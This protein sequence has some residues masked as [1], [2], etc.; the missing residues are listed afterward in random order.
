MN[1][2]IIIV[3]D[4]YDIPHQYHKSFDDEKV[5]ITEETTGK[6]SQVLGKKVNSF[7]GFNAKEKNTS[8]VSHLES[9]WT[10]IIYLELPHYSFGEFGIKFYS[11]LNTGLEKFPSGE[12]M[13]KFNINEENIHTIFSSEVNLWKEYGNIPA[14]YN[15]MVLFK[16]SRWHSCSMTTDIRC[17]K[18]LIKL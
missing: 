13:K 6:I 7:I 16:S 11:H 12:E 10:A 15:R 2:E 1:E 5:L 9:D 17:Q 18:I 8:I 4:F 14:V 3:D